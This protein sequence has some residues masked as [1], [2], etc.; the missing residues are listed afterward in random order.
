VRRIETQIGRHAKKFDAKDLL[1][2]YAERLEKLVAKKE[3]SK[4]AVVRVEEPEEEKG[5]EIVDL[6]AALRR[7]LDSQGRKA[8]RRAPRKT[9]SA[10]KKTAAKRK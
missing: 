10:K 3:K 9:T 8:P 1:D 5:G 2:D 4:A 7:S 6:M